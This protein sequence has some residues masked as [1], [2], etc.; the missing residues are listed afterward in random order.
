MEGVREGEVGGCVEGAR[1]GE[2][3]EG[4]GRRERKREGDDV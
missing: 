3:W 4:D 1:E 2:R